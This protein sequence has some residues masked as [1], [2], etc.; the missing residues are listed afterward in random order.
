MVMLVLMV[1]APGQ[2]TDEEYGED[3]KYIGG[4]KGG[5]G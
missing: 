4:E 5:S 1:P 2:E 3:E